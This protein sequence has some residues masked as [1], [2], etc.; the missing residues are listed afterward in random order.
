MRCVHSRLILLL[1]DLT[2]S[3]PALKHPIGFYLSFPTFRPIFLLSSLLSYPPSITVGWFDSHLLRRRLYCFMLSWFVDLSLRPKFIDVSIEDVNTIFVIIDRA[4]DRFVTGVAWT[5][6]N[7][8]IARLMCVRVHMVGSFFPQTSVWLWC[9]VSR[10]TS[11]RT[12]C[13]RSQLIRC[14]CCSCVCGCVYVASNVLSPL[15]SRYSGQ[16]TDVVSSPKPR[17]PTTVQL[18][19]DWSH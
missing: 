11:A 8:S 2:F 9:R 10:D 5:D 14:Y 15:P 18:D 4:T 12:T 17:Y 16:R 13:S 1:L 3:T 19:V 7:V 6:V